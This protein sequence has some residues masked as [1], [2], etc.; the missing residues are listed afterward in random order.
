[1]KES[2]YI[3]MEKKIFFMTTGA[4]SQ[5]SEP[6]VVYA[7]EQLDWWCYKEDLNSNTSTYTNKSN[8]FDLSEIDELNK[9]YKLLKSQFEQ[10]DNLPFIK[11]ETL[12]KHFNELIFIQNSINNGLA[13]FEG[14]QGI[15]FCDVSAKG[16]QI[17]GFHKDIKN[18]AYGKQITIKYDF[19]NCLE[20]VDEFIEMWKNLDT[21]ALIRKEKDFISMGEKYGWD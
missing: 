9:K 6:K 11:Y 10:F 17:R 12:E 1:M 21:P 19:S 20:A 2:C 3:N 7:K 15:D 13:E 4:V 18:Y 8:I 5:V 16:I 14:F